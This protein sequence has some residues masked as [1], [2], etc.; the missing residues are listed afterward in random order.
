M[1]RILDFA[2][3]AIG[4]AILSPLLLVVM[5]AIK[6]QDHGPVFYRAR[7]VGLQG[8]EFFLFKFR[9]MIVHADKVGPGI[10]L[11]CDQ[12]I[13]QVGRVLRHYKLDELPQLINVVRGEMALVGPRPEDPRY[14]AMYNEDQ[15]RILSILPGVTSPA[16]LC[17]KDENSILEGP[18]WGKKYVTEVAPQKIAIDLDYF[19]HNTLCTDFGVIF[20][21]IVA[22]V[23]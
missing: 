20:R 17:F 7:R 3:S 8:K 5:I 21:T 15:R 2:L 1:K 22:I 23:R 4:L 14:A 10:T 19:G 9:T 11:A 18:D 16:S 12:R 13:T 6:L